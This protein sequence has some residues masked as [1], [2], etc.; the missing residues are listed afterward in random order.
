[1]DRGRP[2]DAG[3][4]GGRYPGRP[5]RG[6]AATPRVPKPAAPAELARLRRRFTGWELEEGPGWV[7]AHREDPE[8]TRHALATDARTL[9]FLLERIVAEAVSF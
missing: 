5:R 2:R 7:A 3:R 1:M 4:A 9:A 6:G 8:H